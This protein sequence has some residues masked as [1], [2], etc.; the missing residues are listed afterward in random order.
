MLYKWQHMALQGCKYRNLTLPRFNASIDSAN[1]AQHCCAVRGTHGE[2]STSLSRNITLSWI[3]S[4]LIL[5]SVDGRSDPMLALR[6]YM[7]VQGNMCHHCR[8]RALDTSARHRTPRSCFKSIS[9]NN[10]GAMPTFSKSVRLCSS[11]LRHDLL[12]HKIPCILQRRTCPTIIWPLV[13]FHFSCESHSQVI[14]TCKVVQVLNADTEA[15]RNIVP[16]LR[17]RALRAIIESLANSPVNDFEAWAKNKMVLKTL[18]EA[19]RLLDGGYVT[20]EEMEN[21][22]LHQVAKDTQVSFD[23]C[24]IWDLPH[25]ANLGIILV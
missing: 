24:L 9:E 22:L 23:G 25:H 10:A 3:R 7:L 11:G 15:Q 8:K 4:S 12:A 14:I 1:F 2:A 20:E 17:H 16:F 5:T 6:S 19:H 18:K 21:A 13:I